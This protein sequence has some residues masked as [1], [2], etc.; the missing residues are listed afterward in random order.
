MLAGMPMA[1]SHAQEKPLL[2]NNLKG[3]QH[4]GIPVTDINNAKRWYAEK[5][6]FRVVH[7]P[8]VVTADGVI[9]VAFLKKADITIELYQLLGKDLDEVKTRGHGHIDHFAID[10]TDVN[11]ALKDTLKAGAKL[12]SSTP[13]GPKYI[14]TFFSKGVKYV[15]LQGPTAEKVELN[16][17]LDREILPSD[18]TLTGWSHLGIPV[19]DINESK[20]FYRRFGFA[21]VMS[22]E[23]PQPAGAI[24]CSMMQKNGFTIELYQLYGDALAEVSKRKDGH[25]DHIAFDVADVNAACAELKKAGFA[26]LE[27]AP[28]FLNFWDK[29]MKYFNIRGPSGEKLEFSQILN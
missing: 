10:V 17:R 15:V 6:G 13:D 24:K 27:D 5:L 19:V 29:G 22:A 16:Q 12:D 11:K 20:N 1:K 26:T 7:E 2:Q 18:D 4:L 25:I 9:Q 28:V 3:V 23:I 21:D 14:P 8:N